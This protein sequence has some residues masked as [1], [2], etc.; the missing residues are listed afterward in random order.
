MQEGMSGLNLLFRLPAIFG[1][2]YPINHP[3]VHSGLYTMALV[4]PSCHFTAQMVVS[5]FLNRDGS[6]TP[7]LF[8]FT[9]NLIPREWISVFAFTILKFRITIIVKMPSNWRSASNAKCSFFPISLPLVHCP[10]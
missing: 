7:S 10:E 2:K 3:E 6:G 4:A 1:W 9:D 8:V 5:I